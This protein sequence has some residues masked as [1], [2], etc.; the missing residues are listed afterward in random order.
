VKARCKKCD[1]IFEGEPDDMF[2]ME[3][4]SCGARMRVRPKEGAES[5][6]AAKPSKTPTSRGERAQKSDR[7]SGEKSSAP[8]LPAT[9][10]ANKVI[11]G[12]ECPGC[13]ETIALGQEVHNC[14][15]CGASQHQGCW[16]EKGGECA[17]AD[18]SS[19][20]ALKKGSRGGGS[21]D[22]A[23]EDD[24]VD[25]KPCKFCGEPIKATARKC[26]FCNEYQN[27]RDRVNQ[28]KAA[29]NPGDDTLNASEVIF[30]ILCGLIACIVAIVWTVQGKKKGPKLLLITIIAQAVFTVIQLALG[31]R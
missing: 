1:S 29:S 14:E 8:K 23:A 30:G 20:L 28:E 11:A 15:A 9:M 21:D 27:A 7:E 4:P 17:N 26:R 22:D 3:C 13:H 2:V 5:A 10:R 16:D 19:K 12:K 24:G 25:R 6:S 18:C 31:G